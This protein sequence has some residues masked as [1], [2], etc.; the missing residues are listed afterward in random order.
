[1]FVDNE[2]KEGVGVAEKVHFVWDEEPATY[3]WN[4][5]FDLQYFNK[6]DAMLNITVK[7]SSDSENKTY[8][9]NVWLSDFAYAAAKCFTECLKK[10][11]LNTYHFYTWDDDINIRK[12]LIVKAFALKLMSIDDFIY[13][14]SFEDELKLLQLDM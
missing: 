11:G 9:F 5:S 3:E 8:K 10:Y 1:M 14:F 2:G 12:L 6:P 7:R 13:E 4:I